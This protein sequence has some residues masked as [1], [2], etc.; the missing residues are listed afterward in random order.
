MHYSNERRASRTTTTSWWRSVTICRAND[1]P[2]VGT[3]AVE[4]AW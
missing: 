3:P 1:S 4:A 2:M